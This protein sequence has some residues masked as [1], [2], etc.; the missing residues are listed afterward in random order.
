LKLVQAVSNFVAL[1]RV[2]RERL[3]QASCMLYAPPGSGKTSLVKKLAE[4]N[5]LRF[6]PFNITQLIERRD[7]LDCFDTIVTYYLQNPRE[8]LLIFIDEI[9]SHLAGEPAYSAFLTP[10]EDSV[11]IRG[12][13]TFKLPPCFWIFASTQEEKEIKSQ[14]KG[15]DFWSRLTHGTISLD[16]KA[17]ENDNRYLENVYVGVSMILSSFPDVMFVS[18]GVLE[19]FYMFEEHTKLREIRHF[20][21]AFENVQYG[22]VKLSNMPT[23]WLKNEN[24]TRINQTIKTWKEKYDV[25][26]LV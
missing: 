7:I 5:N 6:I 22:K 1:H 14:S 25:R 19:V 4:N 8:P 11:Y 24:Y 23:E 26:I 9:N 12:S 18:E 21:E 20:V 2:Q 17:T 16:S 10:L 13:K 15:S 3:K